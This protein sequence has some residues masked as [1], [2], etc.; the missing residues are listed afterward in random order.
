MLRYLPDG[1]GALMRL[2]SLYLTGLDHNTHS[3]NTA[4]FVLPS[5]GWCTVGH[6]RSFPRIL[7]IQFLG[8]GVTPDKGLNLDKSVKKNWYFLRGGG[9]REWG[10]VCGEND[11]DGNVYFGLHKHTQA[12]V[13]TITRTH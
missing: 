10:G 13:R 12:S 1:L 9:N 4:C 2:C 11:L 7:A 3:S 6:W 8:R 5:W